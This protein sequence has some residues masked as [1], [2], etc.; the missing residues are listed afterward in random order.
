[1]KIGFSL[2]ADVL[3]GRKHLC[4]HSSWRREFSDVNLLLFRLKQEGVQNIE[5]KLP[6]DLQYDEIAAMLEMLVS[7]GFEYTFHAPAGVEYPQNFENYIN[8]LLQIARISEQD[9]NRSS[10]FVIHGLSGSQIEKGKLLQNSKIFIRSV[11]TGL[12][13]TKFKVAF[14]NLRDSTRNGSIRSGTSYQEVLALL[15]NIEPSQMGICWDFGHGY[16]QAERGVHAK[17]PPAE[18]INRT[19]HTHIHDYKNETTHLP[20]GLGCIPYQTYIGRLV[21]SGFQGIYNLELNPDR[22]SDPENFA[23]YII[24][25]IRLLKLVLKSAETVN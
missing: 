20:I 17:I 19:R 4:R 5:I 21:Q 22:I 7:A 12:S 10:L 2:Y 3:L 8:F 14:E 16:A 24:Q 18:F 1:M 23:R 9:F 11:L 13:T 25:S 6:A 15:E